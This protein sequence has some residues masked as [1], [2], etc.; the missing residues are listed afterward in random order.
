MVS[1]FGINKIGN[2]VLD[3][4]LSCPGSMSCC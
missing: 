3:K 2:N 4:I 1:M